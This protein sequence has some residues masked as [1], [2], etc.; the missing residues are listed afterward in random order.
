LIIHARKTVLLTLF[1]P[2]LGVIILMLLCL[3]ACASPQAVP[4]PTSPIS[5]TAAPQ[6]APE[7]AEAIEAWHLLSAYGDQVWPGWG[8]SR[9][10]LL[11]RDGEDD[12]LIGHPAPPQGFGLLPDTTVAD[13]S[14]Y[15]RAGHLV[16]VPAAT[17]WEVDGVWSVAVPTRDEFQRAID[18]QLGKGVVQLDAVNYIRAIVHEAF[19]AYAM[20]AIHGQVPDFGA[21]VDEAKMIQ[22]LSTLPDLDKLYAAEGQ[23]LVKALQTPDEQIARE[24]AAEFLNLRRARRS[25]GDQE[26]A[27]YEQTTEWVEGLARYADVAVMRRAGEATTTPLDQAI[28]YPAANEVWQ[29]FLDQLSNPA[30]SPD[31]FRGRYYLLGAGQ[32]FMLDRFKPDWKGR[33]FK[34]KQS[35]EDLLE[36]ATR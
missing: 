15:R 27:A 7:F 11:I 36:Q 30:A 10:P 23:A 6:A 26:M 33:A 13:Q 19:H 17:A 3:D 18:A 9:I 31:G 25:A 8:T 12:L 2:R 1:R 21:D 20:N 22:R 34:G 35:L 14:I 16:P 32:A 4:T 28:N 24:T 29:Q 5:I